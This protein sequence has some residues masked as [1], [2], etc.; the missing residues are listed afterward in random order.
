MRARVLTFDV[1]STT[2]WVDRGL[3]WSRVNQTE[4]GVA[5]AARAPALGA[6]QF[7]VCLRSDN[8]RA[9]SRRPRCD[10]RRGIPGRASAHKWEV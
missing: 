10:L 7:E 5:A 8:R 6:V 2:R 9:C 4:V 3:R 1:W